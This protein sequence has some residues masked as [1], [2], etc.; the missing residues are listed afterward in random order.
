[1][2]WREAIADREHDTTGFTRILLNL[3][4]ALPGV[5]AAAV[6]VPLNDK[7]NTPINAK[8]IA[9]LMFFIFLSPFIFIFSLIM[10]S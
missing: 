2:V 3:V 10:H 4:Q 7:A 9:N 1:M 5:A 8:T 6:P